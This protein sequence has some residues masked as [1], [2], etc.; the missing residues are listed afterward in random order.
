MAFPRS[1]TVSCAGTRIKLHLRGTCVYLDGLLALRRK[2]VDRG[3]GLHHPQP[4]PVDLQEQQ[5]VARTGAAEVSASGNPRIEY[6]EAH[7]A[8]GKGW[9]RASPTGYTGPHSL[10]A[11]PREA[12]LS[13]AERCPAPTW[14]V[15]AERHQPR[16]ASAAL[17]K[18]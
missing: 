8:K 5:A 13:T 9:R 11:C 6:G 15:A 12:A 1:K 3:G 17:G 4:S 16:R 7:G 18:G 14:H 10:T 2:L